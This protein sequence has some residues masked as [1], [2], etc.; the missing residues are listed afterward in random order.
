MSKT[1]E[2]E[3]REALRVYDSWGKMVVE[4]F[5]EA[6]TIQPAPVYATLAAA[7]RA[8]VGLLESGWE[9]DVVESEPRMGSHGEWEQQEPHIKS[10]VIEPARCLLPLGRYFVAAVVPVEADK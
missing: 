10:S 5:P 6:D 9:F 4:R 1:T 7:A 2:E 8:Y 3:I